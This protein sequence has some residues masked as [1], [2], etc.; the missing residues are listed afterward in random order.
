[1][2]SRVHLLIDTLIIFSIMI[3]LGVVPVFFNINAYR[4]FS[5]DKTLVLQ[6][7]GFILL[8]LILTS[9][10][11]LRSI[12]QKLTTDSTREIVL[13]VF[14]PVGLYMA[15]IVISTFFSINYYASLFGSYERMRGALLLISYVV[16]LFAVISIK[17]SFFI[18]MLSDVLVVT[19]LV[20]SFYG[21]VQ[22]F[23]IAT[24]EAALGIMKITDQIF[25]T[26]GQYLFLAD[27]LLVTIF[28]TLYRLVDISM[29]PEKD[30]NTHPARNLAIFSSY[31]FALFVQIGAIF[32][33]QARTAALTLLFTTIS[34]LFLSFVSTQIRV[35]IHKYYTIGISL[36]SLAL[37]A[38]MIYFYFNRPDFMASIPLIRRFHSI[39][40][41]FTRFD[42]W[43]ASVKALDP[44]SSLRFPP[45]FHNDPK[46]ILHHLFGYGPDTQ[47]A[48]FPQFVPPSLSPSQLFIDR[49]HNEFLDVG[50]ENGVVGLLAYSW[51]FLGVVYI[52]LA[53]LF[54]RQRSGII[55]RAVILV[56]VIIVIGSSMVVLVDRS[57]RLV[58]PLMPWFALM[59][60]N[61]S[62]GWLGYLERR[63]KEIREGRG[64][65]RWLPLLLGAAIMAHY[66]T[67]STSIVTPASGMVF[68]VVLGMLIAWFYQLRLQSTT[69]Q[70]KLQR[71]MSTP[72]ASWIVNTVVVPMFVVVLFSSLAYIL[73][74]YLG[75]FQGSAFDVWIA[76]FTTMPTYA[77]PVFYG[78]PKLVLVILSAL[79]ASIILAPYI[80]GG[81]DDSAFGKSVLF[82]FGLSLVTF[83]L[84]SFLLS[85]WYARI[86][87]LIQQGNAQGDLTLLL[88]WLAYFSRSYYLLLAS[89]IV[90][91]LKVVGFRYR[92]DA[93]RRSDSREV[94]SFVVFLLLSFG[95]LIRYIIPASVADVYFKYG[96]SLS[97]PEQYA[98][99]EQIFPRVLALV[100]YRA[101]YYFFYGDSL[102]HHMKETKT[103]SVSNLNK[104]ERLIKRA[105]A[106]DPF[107]SNFRG[108][109]ANLYLVWY[110]VSGQ[111]DRAVLEK[112]V[113]SART[114]ALLWPNDASRRIFYATILLKA[115]EK[116]EALEQVQWA[117][118]INPNY[119]AEAVRSHFKDYD[120]LYRT[121]LLYQ[122]L[123][124]A[125]DALRLATQ[126]RNLAS[127]K[128][129]KEQ[130]E[131]LIASLQQNNSKERS[132]K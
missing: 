48:V 16:I 89:A 41:L 92:S 68:W 66:L 29:R 2:Q 114:A 80:A 70:P 36:A 112:A 115:G 51:L 117:V 81:E 129:Q 119:A 61:L 103:F 76:N 57:F 13:A 42:I 109:L 8:G 4:S 93:H 5:L 86:F 116:E 69:P 74:F 132:G 39:G 6:W 18:H 22:Y 101:Y 23:G 94:I 108:E 11:K 91:V 3:I 50:I 9:Y 14:V 96:R 107:D 37:L 100:D 56:S 123:G 44:R 65:S 125:K 127:N 111:K 58:F 19:S 62:A 45:D 47:Y 97:N 83:A 126:A 104:S 20:V 113:T 118:R 25:S 43:G 12:Y 128:Q 99:A 75:P 7:I 87:T 122:E 59:G 17:K 77:Q 40:S 90:I 131:A 130:A 28:V 120:I 52:F 63:R 85:G 121:A 124:R 1:M 55:L 10:M 71:F 46:K 72:S 30:W 38:V 54:R 84:A 98:P 67:E 95:I 106:L 79:N 32:L 49:S 60:V 73:I 105:I 110:D 88:S 31:L 102:L 53:S 24:V 34:I 27:Y 35:K 26:I 78:W 15:S 33:T 82:L 21:I 64:T